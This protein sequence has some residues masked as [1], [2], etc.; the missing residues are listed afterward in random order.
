LS[1]IK[2]LAELR[3]VQ[4]VGEKAAS[5]LY[6]AGYTLRTLATA[7]PQDIVKV[8]SCSQKEA[9]LVIANAQTAF[10]GELKPPMTAKEY[11]EELDKTVKIFKTG[12]KKLDSLLGGGFRTSSTVGLSGPQASGKT[13]FC[14][15]MLLE[16]THNHKRDAVFVETELNTFSNR[17]LQEMASGRGWDYDPEKVVLV[18]AKRIRDVGTQYYQY[19]RVYD[20]V[21]AEKRDIGIILVDSFTALFRR[22]YVGRELLPDR[23]AEMGRHLTFL[24]DLAK[25][26][27]AVLICTC[28]ILECPVSPMEARGQMS[29]ADVKAQFG[30]GYMVWGGHVLRHTLGTWISLVK[31]KKDIWNATLFDSSELPCGVVEFKISS[32]G[33]DDYEAKKLV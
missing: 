22:K 15:Q 29:S 31:K 14:N 25:E 28:Q 21:T 9:K 5:A 2:A 17:R 27:N 11:G 12:S 19:Q 24:E 33:I 32:K 3:K 30:T 8:L 1:S 18:P 4:R 7:V 26:W 6:N 20:V 23:S 10:A 16:C 13:Q